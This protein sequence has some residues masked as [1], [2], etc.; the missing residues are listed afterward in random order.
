MSICAQSVSVELKKAV[1][2]EETERDL[3]RAMQIYRKIIEEDSKTRQLVAEAH[4]RLATCHLKKGESELAAAEFKKIISRFS[5]QGDWTDLAREQLHGIGVSSELTKVTLVW[6]NAPDPDG[7]VSPDARHFSFADPETGNLAVRVLETGVHSQLTDKVSWEESDDMAMYGMFSR[8]GQRVLFSWFNSEAPES[9]RWELRVVDLSTKSVNTIAAD[10]FMQPVGWSSSGEFVYAYTSQVYNQP[11]REYRW[12]K[13]QLSNRSRTVIRK[14]QR[15]RGLLFPTPSPDGRHW[16]YSLREDSPS[17]KRNI[18]IMNIEDGRISILANTSADERFVGWHPN[19]QGVFY[20]SDLRG[21]KDIWFTEI[22][23]NGKAGTKPAKLVYPNLGLAWPRNFTNDGVLYYSTGASVDFLQNAKFNVSNG[24]LEKGP[25]FT[26]TRIAVPD[27]RV[28]S[29]TEDRRLFFIRRSGRKY[30]IST[31]DPDSGS[32]RDITRI[33]EHLNGFNALQ[34]SPEGQQVVMGGMIKDNKKQGLILIE[35]KN[36]EIETIDTESQ[37]YS[38]PYMRGMIQ[39]NAIYY[40]R[41]YKQEKQCRLVRYDRI[42]KTK[43]ETDI[44][45]YEEN[46][47][48]AHQFAMKWEGDGYLYYSKS[49]IVDGDAAEAVLVRRHVST[50]DELELIRSNETVILHLEGDDE[51]AFISI[52]KADG[53]GAVTLVRLD[54][55]PGGVIERFRLDL[56]RNAKVSGPLGDKF[57]FVIEETVAGDE[58]RC[59]LQAVEMGT[60]RLIDTGLELEAQSMRITGVFED[61][62]VYFQQKPGHRYDIWKLEGLISKAAK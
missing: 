24:K 28:K 55:T 14:I 31:G 35:L 20:T 58:P 1:Y 42:T 48:N 52:K 27:L 59:S 33:D 15:G 17:T 60:G 41:L 22:D 23:A 43:I 51:T 7:Y 11:S 10:G 8:D 30:F 45:E 32:V 39:E 57:L 26:D 61:G 44:C 6:A 19:S 29:V 18:E 49:K 53:S 62:T 34:S 9:K 37:A 4:F 54:F 3:D 40:I 36:G 46:S 12:E 25:D 21:M 13:I 47:A 2:A 50:G 16:A 38:L 5:D 56:P